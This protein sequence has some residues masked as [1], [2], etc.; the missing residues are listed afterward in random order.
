MEREREIIS[1][2]LRVFEIL[3]RLQENRAERNNVCTLNS[4]VDSRITEP[5]TTYL[6]TKTP[7]FKENYSFVS[8][9]FNSKKHQQTCAK[10]RKKRKAKKRR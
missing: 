4:V 10:N 8:N 6:I 2:E 3:V 9:T 1:R 7:E 5:N